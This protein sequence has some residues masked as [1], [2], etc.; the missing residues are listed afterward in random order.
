L[1]DDRPTAS[2]P[3]AKRAITAPERARGCLGGSAEARY[4]I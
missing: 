4:P 3:H 2:Q 1:R